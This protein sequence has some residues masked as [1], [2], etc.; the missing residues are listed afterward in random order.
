[1]CCDAEDYT[2]DFLSSEMY[3]V[4][5]K[6]ANSILLYITV[7]P[8]PR[9]IPLLPTHILDSQTNVKGITQNCELQYGI[10]K[11]LVIMNFIGNNIYRGPLKGS[12]V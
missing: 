11:N 10:Y 9:Q 7:S 1:M 5:D 8:P 6:H 4:I 12:L 2:R 3:K